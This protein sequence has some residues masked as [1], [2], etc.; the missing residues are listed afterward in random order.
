[1]ILAST[2]HFGF[3]NM[4]IS[5]NH[6]EAMMNIYRIDVNNVVAM[7]KFLH[8]INVSSVHVGV[9]GNLPAN[10]QFQQLQRVD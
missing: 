8:Y 6:V 10:I 5:T 9:D 7:C 3:N 1:M 4:V 2:C